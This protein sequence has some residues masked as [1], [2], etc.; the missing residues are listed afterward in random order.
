MTIDELAE[1]I[2]VTRTAIRVHLA[3]LQQDGA[4][5]QRGTQKGVSK[6][7]R[8]YRVTTEAELLLSNAY[9]PILTQLLHVLAGRMPRQEFNSILREVGRGLMAGRVMRHG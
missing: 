1:E 7:A 2:G 4:V 5:E 3:T 6:P 9:V 8:T